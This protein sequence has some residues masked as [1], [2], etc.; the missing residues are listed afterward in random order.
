MTG[1]RSL[2]VLMWL[3]VMAA[4]VG[5]YL[6]HIIGQGIGQARCSVANAGWGISEQGWQIGLMVACGLAAVVSEAAAIV[7]YLATKN[8][9]HYDDAPPGGRIQMFAIAAMCTNFLFLVMIL[10]DGTASII[11]FSCRNS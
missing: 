1:R 6:Q 4:P 7:V 2:H 5:W 9:H 8:D 3:G 11:D 10:L